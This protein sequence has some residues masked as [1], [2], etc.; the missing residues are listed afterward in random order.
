M[1]YQMNNSMQVVCTSSN[2]HQNSMSTIS[3]CE[4][5]M[6]ARLIQNVK[7][8]LSISL[9][10]YN[11]EVVIVRLRPSCKLTNDGRQTQGFEDLPH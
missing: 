10:N 1:I 9:H 5:A 2:P 3:K 4:D 7:D 8:V 11:L 6:V